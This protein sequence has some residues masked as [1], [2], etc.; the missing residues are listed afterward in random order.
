MRNS[1][2]RL[3]KFALATLLVACSLILLPH[4]EAQQGV[5]GT[6]TQQSPTQLHAAAV[7]ATLDAA[8][9]SATLTPPAGQS[10]YLT[11]IEANI[12]ATGT[13]VAAAPVKLTSAGLTGSPTF[14]LWNQ[15]AL[16]IGAV[17]I[18]LFLPISNGLKGQTSTAVS[19]TGAA[20]TSVV[21]HVTICGYYA[22]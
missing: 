5:P 3:Q 15:T 16:T 12:G 21:W 1:M 6:L 20:I 22:P 9:G 19:V 4:A 13:V 18:P 10:V 17:G 8:S 2:K 14:G 7:C 11:Y